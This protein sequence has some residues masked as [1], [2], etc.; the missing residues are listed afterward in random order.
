[1]EVLPDDIILNIALLIPVKYSLNLSQTQKRV[2]NSLMSNNFWRQ[3]FKFDYGC[4]TKKVDSW[5]EEYQNYG[6]VIVFGLNDHGELGF[7]SSDV[8]IPPTHLWRNNGN[9]LHEPM[10]LKGIRARSVSCGH[11]H[12]IMINL[13]NQVVVCGDNSQKQ[14][15]PGGARIYKPTSI[16]GLFAKHVYCSDDSSSIVDLEGNLYMLGNGMNGPRLNPEINTKYVCS[17]HGRDDVDRRQ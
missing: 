17:G 10:I 14:I 2:R 13:D 4:I 5:L 8:F 1:M 7:K 9:H 12:T 16:C 3:K 6:R 15:G 11:F